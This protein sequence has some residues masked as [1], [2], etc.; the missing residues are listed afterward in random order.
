MGRQPHCICINYAWNAECTW[1]RSSLTNSSEARSVGLLE[2]HMLQLLSRHRTEGDDD[3]WCSQRNGA[4]LC[5]NSRFP[6]SHCQLASVTDSC[7][8]A[9]S[10]LGHLFLPGNCDVWRSAP[11]SRTL[12]TPQYDVIWAGRK[13]TTGMRLAAMARHSRPSCA[14]WRASQ[15]PTLDVWMH[16]AG[17]KRVRRGLQGRPLPR[18][19]VPEHLSMRANQLLQ[20]VS[21]WQQ[22]WDIE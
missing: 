20:V 8:K 17:G 11:R 16:W 1:C 9:G 15:R 18:H 4:T 19:K 3:V 21:H 6:V 7:C 10:C 12:D 2:A 14:S 5:F 22:C 13:R